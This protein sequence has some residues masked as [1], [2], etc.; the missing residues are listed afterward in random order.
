MVR[1]CRNSTS[2]RTHAFI[3]AYYLTMPETDCSI[4]TESPHV[5]PELIGTEKFLKILVSRTVP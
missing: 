4:E 2:F 5:K 1:K 3:D